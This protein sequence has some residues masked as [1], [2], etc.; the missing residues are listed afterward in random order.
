MHH[1]SARRIAKWSAL[2]AWGARLAKRTGTKKATV[3]MARKL[4]RTAVFPACYAAI[5]ATRLP[6][7]CRSICSQYHS[8]NLMTPASSAGE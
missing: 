1:A 7:R 6:L 8:T 2:K 3:A 4:E 5:R